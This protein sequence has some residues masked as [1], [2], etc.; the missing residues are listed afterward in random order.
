MVVNFKINLKLLSLVALVSL[1]G[2][3]AVEAMEEEDSRYKYPLAQH[4]HK[5]LDSYVKEFL[6]EQKKAIPFPIP[7]SMFYTLE[8]SE[9]K[10]GSYINFTPMEQKPRFFTEHF[11]VHASGGP[12]P[13]PDY[14][15]LQ[16]RERDRLIEQR[17]RNAQAEREREL[18]RIADFRDLRV[19]MYDEPQVIYTRVYPGAP[20]PQ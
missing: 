18:R 7:D 16:R 11:P 3:P 6:E 8:F 5:A 12:P 1:C 13:E 15:E 2:S 10:L 19:Q 9:F 17:E 20:G 14:A 4:A